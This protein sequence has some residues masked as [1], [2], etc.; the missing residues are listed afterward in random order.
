MTELTHHL[1][2]L[3]QFDGILHWCFLIALFGF[4]I[5]MIWMLIRVLLPLRH[6]A[7][8]ADSAMSGDLPAFTGR[9][10]IA[11]IAT[12]RQAL[13]HM[14][15]QV[16]LAQQREAAYREALAETLEN[17]RKRIAREIHDDTIQSLIVIAHHIERAVP[18]PR[19]HQ[20]H[21]DAAR[22]HIIR[23]IDNL[24]QMIADLR[25]TV[26]DELGLIAALEALCEEHP[27]LSLVV[28]G[29]AYPL[30][31]AQEL[32]LF[33]AAQ[34]AVHNALNHAHARQIRVVL[35][36]TERAVQLEVSD[37]G[38]GF[39]PP[40]QL[41]ELARHGHYGLIGLCERIHYIGG[42]VSIDS[43]PGRGTQIRVTLP[44]AQSMACA[45]A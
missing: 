27:A 32:A 2:H 33:R 21:L 20:P 19:G 41:Q 34:E 1:H 36:Y 38:I 6:L 43:Q 35:H 37:D 29:Q 24:R 40:A 3:L 30:E 5:G 11:E 12:L 28:E 17:E 45:V 7:R 4:A 8:Q 23:T 39:D 26:L 13:Q 10:G 22:A 15:A 25:P 16:E 42:A 14:T 18:V 44:S 9:G 31:A